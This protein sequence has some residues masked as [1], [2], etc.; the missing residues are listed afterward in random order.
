M[1]ERPISRPRV[2]WAESGAPEESRPPPEPYKLTEVQPFHGDADNLS[3]PEEENEEMGE[4]EKKA[5]EK[6]EYYLRNTEEKDMLKMVFLKS[7]CTICKIDNNKALC[8]KLAVFCRENKLAKEVEELLENEPME[9]EPMDQL[10]TAVQYHAM[11]AITAMSRVKAIAQDEIRSL[12][13]ACFKAIFYLPPKEVLNIHL[14]NHTMHA[15]D[16][17]LQMLLVSH[18]TSSSEELQN[19]L[20]VLL[21]FASSQDKTVQARAM[22]RLWKLSSF[23]ASNSWQE[24]FA[25]FLEPSQRTDIVCMT[26]ETIGEGSTEDMEW[27]ISMLDV[28]LQDPATWMMDVPEILE[29]IQRNLGSSSTSLQEALFSVLDVLTIQSPRDVLRSVLTDLPQCDSTTLDIW[30]RIVTLPENS[31][32][33]LDEL[34]SIFQDKELC[35]IFNVTTVELG[36]L[37]FTVMDPTEENLQELHNPAQLRQLLKIESLPLVWLVLRGLVLLSESSEMARRIRVLLPEVM[38]TLRFAN[39]PIALKV[40]NIFRNVMTHLGKYDATLIAVNLAE[41][42]LPLFNHVASEVREGSICLFKDLMNTVVWCQK[43]NMKKTVRKALLPLVF[44]MSDETPSIAEVSGETLIAC[45]KFL[46]WKN[47]KHLAKRKKKMEIKE[48]LVQQNRQMVDEYLWQNLPYLRDSQASLRYE[49]VEFI[50][51]PNLWVPLWAL[52]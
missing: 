1:E 32:W 16:N 6:I 15:M 10:R 47:L 4:N 7:I 23:I 50:G 33:I 9:N 34:C 17:M 48:C 5:M 35:G 51:E 28:V 21:H 11:L 44:Q 26:L 39:T 49:A 42:L 20:E 29:F 8:K 2:A 14:Y 41:D 22:E 46:K 3:L 27:A 18:R 19:I 24:P 13:N 43:R 12:L 40:L 36:L 31:E 37:R 25:K 45:A 52:S 30:K 38:G